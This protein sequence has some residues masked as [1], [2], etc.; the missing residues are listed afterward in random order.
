MRPA[1]NEPAQAA[2]A[3]RDLRAGASGAF[4]R[5]VAKR[6]GA[7]AGAAAHTQAQSV[8]GRHSPRPHHL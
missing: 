1:G 6:A 2:R 8:T 4:L 3:L 5:P 7:I